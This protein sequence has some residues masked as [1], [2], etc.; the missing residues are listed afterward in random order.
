VACLLGITT[1]T[2][3]WWRKKGILQAVQEGE[4]GPWWYSLPP[5]KL[6]DLRVRAKKSQSK[7]PPPSPPIPRQPPREPIDLP[8]D[9]DD[10]YSS[11]A[12]AALAGVDVGTVHYWRRKAFVPA[13]K[14]AESG[15]WKH[16]VSPDIL[17]EL[18]KKGERSRQRCA[19]TRAQDVEPNSRGN[20]GGA[21]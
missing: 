4:R 11:R 2:V 8:P 19:A 16:M 5:E 7:N 20:E 13:E 9:M 6:E 15:R 12:L 1:D 18:R 17:I 10:G 14:D 3:H 21:V